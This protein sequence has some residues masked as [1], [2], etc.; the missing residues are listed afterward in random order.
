M[1][2]IKKT[3]TPYDDV[4]RTLLNDCTSLI[5]PVINEVFGEHYT[6]EEE[7]VFSVN[8]HFLNQQD[9]N[10][11]KRT[12]DGNFKVIGKETKKYHLECQSGPDSSMLV[13]LFE[14]GTQIALDEGEIEGNILTVTFPHTAV[15]FL[16]CNQSTPDTMKI[17]MITPGGSVVYDI[18]VMKSK[19]YT[20]EEIFEKNLLFLIPFYIFSY[21][22]RFAEYEKDERKTE[23]LEQE[24]E[25]IKNRL[26]ELQHQGVINEY[27]RR[28][29]I[30]MSN[31]VVEHI[32]WKFKRIR[33]GVQSVM[34][35]KVLE[36]EAKT[37]RNEGIELGIQ[38]GILQGRK[39][40]REEGIRGTVSVLKDLGI[41]PQTILKKIQEQY[42]LSPEISKK[43]L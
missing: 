15:L 8:E 26:E 7:V 37:I 1:G 4:F 42:N 40:G 23:A 34:G 19:Q 3:S 33:E 21:E 20:L 5:I 2:E 29:I 12:T 36:H 24:Y 39:E 13:R 11:E 17:R 31:K 25:Q 22:D 43:Y 9:G 41:A 38:T 10:E 28:T 6:G 27:T 18:P 32:A 16:R 30:E 14:Y 35:G